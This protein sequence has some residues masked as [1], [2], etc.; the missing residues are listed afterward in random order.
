MDLRPVQRQAVDNYWWWVVY[1]ADKKDYSP[2]TCF[3]KYKTRAACQQA[4][5]LHKEKHENTNKILIPKA[6]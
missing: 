6:D 2:L 5:D 4:I 1:D 3:G